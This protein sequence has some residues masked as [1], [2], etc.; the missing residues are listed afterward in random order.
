MP[1]VSF[2]EFGAGL[3][4]KQVNPPAPR[5]PEPEKPQGNMLGR[6]LKDA[7]GDIVETFKG[8]IGA[9]R[10]GAENFAQAFQQPGLSIPQRVVGAAVA[11]LSAVVNAGGEALKGGAKLLTTDE[12]EE[13]TN[14]ALVEVGKSAMNSQAGM[15]LRAFYESLPDD[16]KFTVTNIIAPVG[17]VMTAG[18]GGGA[19]NATKSALRS[20]V[21]ETVKRTSQEAAE[22]IIRSANPVTEAVETTAETAIKTADMSAN[23]VLDTLKGASTQIKDYAKRT[24]NEAQDTA[25]ESRRLAQMPKPKAQLIRNGADERIVNVVERMTPE[26]VRVVRESIAQSRVYE[27]LPE[28]PKNH[29]KVIAGREFMKPV[30]FVIDQRKQVGTKLGEAR[31]NLSQTRNIDTNEAFRNFHEYLKTTYQIQLDKDGKIIPETG[32]LATGD[33]PQIQKL[34][35]QLKGSKLNSQ[36]ELDQWLQRS[37]KDYDLVQKREQTFSEEVPKIAEVARGEVSKLMP[38][39]YNQLRTQYAQMSKPLNEVV[40]LLQYKGS[41]DQLTAKELKAA[42]VALRVLGNAAD[43]PQSVIDD[44]L[45]I[46]T[47]NGYKSNVDINRLLYVTDQLE[48]LYDVTPPRGF[49]G[50]ATRGINQSSAGT[51]IDAATFNVGGLFDRAMSSRASQKE[52][53]ESFEA[54]VQYL[55]GGGEKGA[56]VPAQ[57]KKTEKIGIEQEVDELISKAPESKQYI[58]EIADSVAADIPNVR[59]AKAPIKSKDRAIEKIMFEEAG[60]VTKLRD[61]A[62][63]S[64]VPMD[65]KALADSLARMDEVLLQT[66]GDGLFARKKIQEPEKFSGYGGVIYN[67]ETPNGMIAEIQV[68]K[69]G[70]IFGKMLPKDAK[71]ILGEDLFNKIAA[72]TGI[73]PGYGHKLYED[74]RNLSI[75]DL[76]GVK[77]QALIKESVDYY[78][79]LR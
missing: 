22:A 46:A 30:G 14:K 28:D 66:K 36:T 31:K 1:I 58:D 3:P 10:G 79:K 7:P 62:R 19:V 57:Q 45:E 65:S 16:Q 2:K 47:E 4:V 35:D 21:K 72:D 39:N 44:I 78:N 11:P 34:Y 53:Q 42:E 69:P 32:T 51:A 61:L 29:P 55:D 37:L 74:L 27:K 18:F 24:A 38:D 60:D 41:L 71:E 64:I 5:I 70:M 40:K 59:V 25:V 56:F 15:A 26:E 48:D 23:P 8:V 17:N 6:I 9:G 13:Q 77:G 76:E 63:N 68:V 43:R 33:V 75:A 52:I 12:F 67:I 54:Y 20:T 73:E 49:S 50:S